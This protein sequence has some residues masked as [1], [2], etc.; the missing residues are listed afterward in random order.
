MARREHTKARIRDY[1]T[2][3]QP[4][5]GNVKDSENILTTTDVS[6]QLAEYIGGEFGVTITG[7]DLTSNTDGSIEGITT[8]VESQLPAA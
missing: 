5:K 3:T 6:V 1:V 2:K 8:Y 4:T 7:A